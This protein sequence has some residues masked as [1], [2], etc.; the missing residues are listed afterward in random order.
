MVKINENTKY[1]T[2]YRFGI[3]SKSTSFPMAMPC[4]AMSCHVI[5]IIPYPGQAQRIG[6]QEDHKAQVGI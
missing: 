1:I 4:H 5:K 3:S 2:M 6:Q